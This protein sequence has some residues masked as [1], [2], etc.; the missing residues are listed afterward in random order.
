MV[1]PK[2]SLF[3]KTELETLVFPLEMIAPPLRDAMFSTNVHSSTTK[4]PTPSFSIAPPYI[5]VL[6][7]NSES[8]TVTLASL[9][10]KYTAPPSISATLPM[11]VQLS[12][13]ESSAT[14][15]RLIAPPILAVFLLNLELVIFADE[16]SAMTN[17]AAP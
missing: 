4:S 6:S 11:K 16:P 14:P 7:M 12:I 5:A 8:V 15:A 1:F 2:A 9:L 17:I 10:H 3:S 13:M